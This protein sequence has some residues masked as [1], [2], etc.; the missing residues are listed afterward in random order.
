[1]ILNEAIKHVDF[2]VL[3][4]HRNEEDQNEAFRLGNSTKQWPNSKHNQKP[5]T[6]V[7][8]APWFGPQVKI[9]WDDLL[10]FAR[11]AG[12]L[13]AIAASLKIKIRWGA[14]WNDNGRSKDE[15]FIDAGHFEVIN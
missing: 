9:D 6:A 15:R 5:S 4:G 11:L 8:V 3:C 13:E 10:A 1:M 14:D 7:D 2:T 12:F